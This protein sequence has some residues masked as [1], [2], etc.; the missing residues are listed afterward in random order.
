MNVKVNV[1]KGL[2]PSKKE[3]ANIVKNIKQEKDLRL[4]IR[5]E[6]KRRN[7][8]NKSLD[9]SYLVWY[10]HLYQLGSFNFERRMK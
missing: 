5:E 10:N 4:L 3:Y 9:K 6:R 7:I 2:K 1:P 8:M